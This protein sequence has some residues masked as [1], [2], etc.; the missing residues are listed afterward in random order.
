VYQSFVRDYRA[1][2]LKPVVDDAMVFSNPVPSKD[3]MLT[4]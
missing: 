4:G 3:A 1:M 2:K